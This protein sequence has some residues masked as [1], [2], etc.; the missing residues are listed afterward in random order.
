MC[1]SSGRSTTSNSRVELDRDSANSPRINGLGKSMVYQG[2][3]RKVTEQA[4]VKFAEEPK[5]ILDPR[6]VMNH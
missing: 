2:T 1:T 5:R 3:E 4:A 6:T